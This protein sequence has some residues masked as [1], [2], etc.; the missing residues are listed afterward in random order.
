[1]SE[2]RST[3]EKDCAK[4]DRNVETYLRNH[5]RN[6]QAWNDM[7]AQRKASDYQAPKSQ[8]AVGRKYMGVLELGGWNAKSDMLANDWYTQ[9]GMAIDDRT[10]DAFES[11]D[12]DI[13]LSHA[14]G[15]ETHYIRQKELKYEKT[16]R[17]GSREY[18]PSND[19]A[20]AFMAGYKL[21]FTS[22]GEIHRAMRM[23]VSHFADEAEPWDAVE[24]A[25]VRANAP[26]QSRFNLK[27]NNK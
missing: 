20:L 4:I 5:E 16:K 7:I 2:Y 1:M 3:F 15:R 26:K 14:N 17:L 19:W 23:I 9:S 22:E 18:V 11:G 13:D 21:R 25:S 8:P 6:Q 24:W 10:H 27:A 12:E